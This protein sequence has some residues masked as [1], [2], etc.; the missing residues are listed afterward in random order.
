[1]KISRAIVSILAVT[2]LAGCV[3]QPQGPMIPVMPGKNKS[4]SDFQQND[5]ECRD[6]AAG[7]VAGRAQNANDHAILSTLIGAGLGAALGGAVGGGRGAG[8]GAA[9]G[10]IVG[11][12]AGADRSAYAQGSLQRQYDIAY[13]QC[14]SANGNELTDDQRGY[15]RG[16]HR[17]NDD[18]YGPPP[19][20]PYNDGY[21]P[22]PPPAPDN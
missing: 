2:F 9:S 20:R 6:F 16:W 17:P 8:I 10:G 19:R 7:R 1:M 18:S 12:A 22:P 11:T 15:R 5:A 4:F 21:G 13:A 14:M 3:V